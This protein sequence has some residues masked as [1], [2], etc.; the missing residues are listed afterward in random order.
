MKHMATVVKIGRDEPRSDPAQSKKPWSSLATQV[1]TPDLAEALGLKGKHGVRVT[2][3][4]QGQAG[5][6]AGFQVGD[7]ITAVDGSPLEVSQSE[8]DGVFELVVRRKYIG[9]EATFDVLREGKPRAIK[10][11]LEAPAQA[12]DTPRAQR[13]RF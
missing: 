11:K 7:I 1:V 6:K 12:V 2:E 3:V 9:D 4:Y 10:M 5:E 8:D 13:R